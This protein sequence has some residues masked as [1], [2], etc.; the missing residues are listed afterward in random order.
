MHKNLHDNSQGKFRKCKKIFWCSY[1]KRNAGSLCLKHENILKKFTPLMDKVTRNTFLFLD[2][3]SSETHS[4]F[5]KHTFFK[6]WYRFKVIGHFF[7]E[8]LD[9]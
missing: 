5:Q 1:G 3:K 7:F 8:S 9:I 6:K 4:F 2:D